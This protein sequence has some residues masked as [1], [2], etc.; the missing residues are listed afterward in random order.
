MDNETEAQRS[1]ISSVMEL[2][3]QLRCMQLQ[4]PVLKSTRSGFPPTATWP[5]VLYE[6]MRGI[7][8]GPV[9]QAL[10]GDNQGPAKSEAANAEL[11]L[12]GQNHTLV[13]RTRPQDN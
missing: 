6:G 10:I 8:L 13:S 12:A 9:L 3:R 1:H 5:W 11:G 4:R 7:L 2:E